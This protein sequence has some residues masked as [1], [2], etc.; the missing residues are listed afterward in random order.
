MP[1]DLLLRDA[2]QRGGL[3]ELRRR[4]AAAAEL[5]E[6]LL[7]RLLLAAPLQLREGQL[8]LGRRE[9]R[10][11]RNRSR[12]PPPFRRRHRRARRGCDGSSDLAAL[13]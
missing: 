13:Y 6:Q 4:E 9:R 7:A 11:L 10:G 1:L 3:D 8:A 2:A 12:P 5:V